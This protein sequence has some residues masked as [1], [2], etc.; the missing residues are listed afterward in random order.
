MLAVCPIARPL[1]AQKGRSMNRPQPP[2]PDPE[3]TVDPT[4]PE[5]PIPTSPPRHEDWLLDEALRETFPA[6]DPI[7]PAK[8]RPGPLPT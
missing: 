8:P 1:T 3:S 6:S 4:R 2:D 7:S 5:T